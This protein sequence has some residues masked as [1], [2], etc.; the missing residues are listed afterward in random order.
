VD[1]DQHIMSLRDEW[2]QLPIMRALFDTN[3]VIDLLAGYPPASN[4]AARCPDLGQR[5]TVWS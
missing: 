3:I 4:Q 1:A 5:P 2:E